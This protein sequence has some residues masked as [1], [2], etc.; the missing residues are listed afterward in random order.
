MKK[1]PRWKQASRKITLHRES[2]GAKFLRAR[3]QALLSVC[4]SQS[5]GIAAQF[6]S[7]VVKASSQWPL[8]L[9]MAGSFGT[10]MKQT[11][12]LGAEHGVLEIAVNADTQ[13]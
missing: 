7:F 4:P 13:N 8:L 12:A 11:P 9:G 6:R 10:G 2:R 1:I 5:E 3:G